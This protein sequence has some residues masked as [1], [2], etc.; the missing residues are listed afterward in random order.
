MCDVKSN[1]RLRQS[2]RIYLK[3]I[4]AKFHSDQIWNDGAL[5]FFEDVAPNKKNK[6]KN[7][8]MSSD[9]IRS[10]SKMKLISLRRVKFA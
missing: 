3:S 1:I 6:N 10:W 9:E 5:G 7:N 4:P 8:K 2:M